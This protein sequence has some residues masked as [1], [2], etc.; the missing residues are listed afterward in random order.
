MKLTIS[1][2]LQT[3]ALVIQFCSLFIWSPPDITILLV[4]II[5]LWM[6]HMVRSY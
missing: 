3:A 6:S 1:V 5:L 2:A 4:V